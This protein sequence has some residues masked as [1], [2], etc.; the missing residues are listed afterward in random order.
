MQSDAGR[1]QGGEKRPS[2]DRATYE[3][4]LAAPPDK[5]AEL[6]D[7]ELIL[8]PRPSKKHASVSSLLGADL[9]SAFQRGR[10]GPGGWVILDEPELHLDEDI[11]VPDLAAWRVERAEKLD[12]GAFFT[13][14]PDWVCE[15]LSPSTAAHD[16]TEKLEIYAREHVHHV[17]LLDPVLRTLETF[18]WSEAGWVTLKV[19]HGNEKVRAVPFDAIEMDLAT[20]WPAP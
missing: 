7:G 5:V 12:D 1:N 10:G 18:A 6:I 13:T 9:I 11:L 19:W 8:S 2:H 15:V 4:V 3:D 14:P 17:W 20:L 16:R